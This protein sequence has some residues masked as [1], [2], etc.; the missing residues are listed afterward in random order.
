MGGGFLARALADAGH[1]VLLI[2][3]GNEKLSAP[4]SETASDDPEKRLT[5][6]KWPNP[7]AFEIDG[8]TSR[9]YAPIGSGVGGSANW[10]AAALERFDE[11]DLDSRPESAHPTGGW[12]IKLFRASPVLRAG[13][14]GLPAWWLRDTKNPL[15]AHDSDHLGE[16]PHWGPPIQNLCAIS[17]AADCILTDFTSAFD[18]FPAAMN[19]LASCVTGTAV[20]MPVPFWLKSSMKANHYCLAV[21]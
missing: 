17:K 10:Y 18:T 11:I 20:Q 16:P 9:Q 1:D 3:R 8:V 19:A 2:E 6:N 13:P 21:R 5:E 4:G 14:S 12:P 7:N 15:S